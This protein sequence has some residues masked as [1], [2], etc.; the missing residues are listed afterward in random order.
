MELYLLPFF[1]IPLISSIIR[2][3]K[4]NLDREKW[5]ISYIE[6]GIALLGVTLV[7]YPVSTEDA[8]RNYKYLAIVIIAIISPIITHLYFKYLSSKSVVKR[9]KNSFI[10][11][12]KI[13]YFSYRKQLDLEGYLDYAKQEIIF[14][15]ITNEILTSDYIQLIRKYL[16]E[17]NIKIKI[18]LLNPDSPYIKDK[19]I[20]FTLSEEDLKKRIKETIT[21]LCNYKNSLSK[22]KENLLILTHNYNIPESIIIIDGN[23]DYSNNLSSVKTEKY[24]YGSDY[25]SRRSQIVFLKDSEF[26]YREVYG[27]YLL[28]R[29]TI[30]HYC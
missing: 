28:I 2:I 4:G 7:F 27:Q 19:S 15:S 6:I 10:Q 3:I 22:N 13:Q 17:K 24:E 1:L 23:D 21:L 20:L 11:Q 25:N 29:N 26:I 16:I 9:F 14:I 30:R 18:I 5:V 8:Y 12:G